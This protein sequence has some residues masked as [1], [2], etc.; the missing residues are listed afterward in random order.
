MSVFV[1]ILLIIF[2]SYSI[3]GWTLYFLQPKYM[4]RPVVGI[5]YDPGDINLTYEKVVLK[6][7]DGTKI[8]AWYVPCENASK[9]VLFCHGNGGNMSHRLDTINVINE[10]GMNCFLFDY[11]GY[12]D[13]QGRAT[14]KGTYLD[15]DAAWDWLTHRKHISGDDIIIFG[16]SMGGCI[17]S[18][19]ASKVDPAAL[20]VESA[21]TSYVDIG[22]K[23]Y[24]YLPVK[25]FAVFEYNTLE[26]IRKVSCPVLVMHSK[27]DEIVPYDF[28]PMLYEAVAG[29]KEF[30]EF[31]GK[32]NDGFLFSGDTYRQAWSQW[33]GFVEDYQQLDEKSHKIA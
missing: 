21:F 14:E 13:S 29:P 27:A 30:V 31:F 18:Y 5:T 25:M 8:S 28:G 16:R 7:D 6:T 33:L 20:V 11:R 4:Y 12:G 10:M 9:T 22:K 1:T 3:L 15:A 32:H 17:A 24:P 19:L 23:C 2:I 26:Y